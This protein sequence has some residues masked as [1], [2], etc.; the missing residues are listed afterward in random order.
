MNKQQYKKLILKYLESKSNYIYATKNM[1]YDNLL[2]N[3]K[4]INFLYSLMK[5]DLNNIKPS[6][7]YF[8]YKTDTSIKID[9]KKIGNAKSFNTFNIPAI[10]KMKST[11]VRLM[12]NKISLHDDKVNDVFHFLLLE[13]RERLVENKELEDLEIFKKNISHSKADGII[14]GNNDLTKDEKI[15]LLSSLKD[16]IKKNEQEP[17]SFYK[18]IFLPVHL[19][20]DIFEENYN[21]LEINIGAKKKSFEHL[22]KNAKKYH[23]FFNYMFPENFLKA[24]EETY[25]KE[26]SYIDP[27]NLFSNESFA[28]TLL[29]FIEKFN[30][31]DNFLYSFFNILNTL[32][33]SSVKIQQE[34]LFYYCLIYKSKDKTHSNKMKFKELIDKSLKSHLIYANLNDKTIQQ[35][36]C[37]LNY[38]QKTIEINKLK[39]SGITIEKLGCENFD[40]DS[41]NKANEILIS[42]K[43]G[44]LK[45]NTMSLKNIYDKFTKTIFNIF[46]ENNLKLTNFDKNFIKDITLYIITCDFD[47]INLK[48]YQMQNDDYDDYSKKDLTLFIQTEDY[49]LKKL[50]F[51][52]FFNKKFERLFIKNRG[53]VKYQKNK[54]QV[55]FTFEDITTHYE[56]YN[57]ESK[58]KT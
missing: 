37:Y 3:Y 52:D 7:C 35:R 34:N 26:L 48:R 8:I 22:K 33:Y 58:N 14:F 36:M 16:S 49:M 44:L 1:D 31:K 2:I 47:Y 6:L 40:I 15:L 11:L 46:Q 56:N 21:L 50:N 5:E 51:K 9:I 42:I 54:Q 29:N 10:K 32:Q 53:K 43:E 41:K 55:K 18:A 28:E 45:T 25:R 17:Y 38:F 4:K 57:I 13:Y 39:N 20:V 19:Y 12:I 23:E 24:I 27:F 30:K